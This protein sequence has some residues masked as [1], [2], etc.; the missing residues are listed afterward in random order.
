MSR[1]SK[2]ESARINGAKSK[3]PVTPEGKAK[4]SR[5]AFTHGAYSELMV[6]DT[7]EPAAYLD[8]S[9][10]LFSHFNPRNIME[11]ELVRDII[12]GRWR[13]HRVKGMET[14]VLN[15][16]MSLQRKEIETKFVTIDVETRTVLAATELADTSQLLPLLQR[17]DT[18]FTRLVYRTIELLAKL[19]S[20]MPPSQLTGGGPSMNA[21]TQP[22]AQPTNQAAAEAKTSEPAAEPAQPAASVMRRPHFLTPERYAAI[23]PRA[24]P[25]LVQENKNIDFRNEPTELHQTP[26]LPAETPESLRYFQAA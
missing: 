15:L 2:A 24:I 7:E 5:N 4:S 1:L 26:S 23:A 6:L 12:D 19:Q 10:Q 14:A 20:D 22:T 17:L 21:G 3:G 16:Q 13:L 18:K 11:E 25:H 9:H 8:L